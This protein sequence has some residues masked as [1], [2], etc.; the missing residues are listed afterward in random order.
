MGVQSITAVVA[1]LLKFIA[2][3]TTSFAE[4]ENSAAVLDELMD[5]SG[6]PIT[7]AKVRSLNAEDKK[8]LH[9]YYHKVYEDSRRGGLAARDIQMK[10]AMLGDPEARD[11]IVMTW[12]RG[13]EDSPKVWSGPEDL[14]R[15]ESPEIIQH[16]GEVLFLNE[17]DQMPFDVGYF[18]PQKSA[19]E[20]IVATLM[21]APAFSDAV[22]QWASQVRPAKG[23]L[24]MVRQWYRDNETLLKRGDFAALKLGRSPLK[25]HASEPGSPAPG[26]PATTTPS[27]SL[28]AT[29]MPAQSS[30]ESVSTKSK[31]SFVAIDGACL[32]LLVVLLIVSK[33][34]G[35]PGVG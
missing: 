27:A 12:V 2:I 33:R 7:M 18:A 3:G 32:T 23:R 28:P 26:N 22:R 5:R 35:K 24:E 16:L 34:R 20:I 29:V 14:V 31:W 13:H 15:L 11:R 25:G 1:I 30:S 19:C 6:D 17:Q 4:D 10:L 9:D 8:L 21:T